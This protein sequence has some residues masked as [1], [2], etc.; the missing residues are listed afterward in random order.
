MDIILGG[1]KI[2]NGAVIGAGALVTK[3]V[4]PYSI[5]GGVPAKIIKMRFSKKH[6]NMLEEFKW[7]N[8]DKEWLLENIGNFSDIL[9]FEKISE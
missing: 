9:K 4:I 6:I 1:I 3:D 5:I 8:K 7:W 2:G